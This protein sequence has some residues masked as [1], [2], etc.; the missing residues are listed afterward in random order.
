MTLRQNRAEGAGTK[1]LTGMFGI[2]RKTLI[3]W[4]VYFRDVFP[5]SA[6]WKKLRGRVGAHVGNNRLPG[7]LLDYFIARSDGAE[8]G[9]ILCLR[10]LAQQG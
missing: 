9:L 4:L 6:Q 10:F 7:D 5:Q 1:W 2:S 8:Q 3:R